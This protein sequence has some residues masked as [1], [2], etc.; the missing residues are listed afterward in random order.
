M[1]AGTDGLRMS[2]IGSTTSIAI[3]VKLLIGSHGTLLIS[4]LVAIVLAVAISSV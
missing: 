2:G 1:L 4:G 3:G